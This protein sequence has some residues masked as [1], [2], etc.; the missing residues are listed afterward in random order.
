MSDLDFD[1]LE[2][3]YARR[4]KGGKTPVVADDLDFDVLEKAHQAAEYNRQLLAKQQAQAPQPL[5][6]QELARQQEANLAA[7]PPEVKRKI[8]AGMLPAPGGLKTFFGEAVPEAY[9]ELSSRFSRGAFAGLPNRAI[10]AAGLPNEPYAQPIPEPGK[11]RRPEDIAPSP[12]ALA[13]VASMGVEGATIGGPLS[14]AGQTI[15]QG[16]AKLATMF[17]AKQAQTAVRP[18]LQKAAEASS[19]G[20]LYSA[21]DTALRGGTPEEIAASAAEGATV[22]LALGQVPAVAGS[23]KKGFDKLTTSLAMKPLKETAK[24]L[25]GKALSQFSKGGGKV[26]GERE[27]RDFIEREELQPDLLDRKNMEAR[28]DSRQQQVWDKEL[29]PI[30]EH[31][32]A[33]EPNSAVSL[34]AIE[35]RLKGLVKSTQRGTGHEEIINKYIDLLKNRADR[36]GFGDRMPLQNLLENAREIQNKGWAGVVNFDSPPESKELARMVGGELRRTVN[37]E[38]ASIYRRNPQHAYTLAAG[39]QWTPMGLTMRDQPSTPKL[40]NLQDYPNRWAQRYENLQ[41]YVED[42]PRRLADGNKRYSDYAK[43]S[44]VVRDAAE[45]FAEQKVSL[46]KIAAGSTAG[47]GAMYLGHQIAGVPGSIAAML[48]VPTAIAAYP[49]TLSAGRG[50]SGAISEAPMALRSGLGMTPS[51]ISASPQA[52]NPGIIAPS[53]LN[54]QRL[55]R[56][57]TIADMFAG[58][59]QR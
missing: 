14:R 43:L 9:S 6:S 2:K 11:F 13:S 52:F 17:G 44:P 57:R 51:Q 7:A 21:T 22:N 55:E 39:Q 54:Q 46:R 37:D 8:E 38:I 27:M 41:D 33:A 47:L 50:M 19:T 26:E 42:V 35:S 16:P 4:S 59:N 23:A 29:A 56:P 49:R 18:A 25:Q 45:R 32:L 40:A 36:A 28:I 12:A 24:K 15:A 10:Q 58:E 1:A 20:A 31:A 5:S 34:S 3:E 53:M 48:G 30:Y